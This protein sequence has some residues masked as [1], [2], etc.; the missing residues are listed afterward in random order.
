VRGRRVGVRWN[1]AAR[2]CRLALPPGGGEG[3]VSFLVGRHLTGEKKWL[4][5]GRVV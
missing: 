2:L 5:F 1:F 3:G 4:D